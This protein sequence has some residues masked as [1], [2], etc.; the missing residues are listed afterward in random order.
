[1]SLKSTGSMRR[2]YIRYI[3]LETAIGMAINA[4]LS[5]GLAYA[6][7]E[8][9]VP[10]PV[11]SLALLLRDVGTQCFIVALMSV[12]VPTLLT[13]RR[14]K[15]GALQSLDRRASWLDNLLLRSVLIA[16][17][18]TV[19]GVA[20]SCAILPR[21]APARFT[22]NAYLALKAA[23]GAIV[24]FTVT[25]IAVHLGLGDSTPI[26]SAPACSAITE[27]MSDQRP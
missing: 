4:T 5:V 15:V 20:L 11:E 17:C 22:I 26:G 6:M 12:L 3:A 13:R 25:P 21:L 7:F 23:V 2:E 27:T 14:C 1:M 10:M 24:A 8:A 16:A 19:I 9:H 18:A